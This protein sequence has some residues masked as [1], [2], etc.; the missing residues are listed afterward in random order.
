M[1]AASRQLILILGGA[2]SGKS[3]FGERLAA[4][5]GERI[6]YLATAEASDDEMQARIARHRA[7]RPAQWTTRECPFDPAA[8]L[9]AA[10][11]ETDCFLLDCLTLLVS[12]L[13]LADPASAEETVHCAMDALLT[14]YRETEA[15][16][17]IVSNE[18]GLG[19]VPEYPLGRQYR[20]LLGKV[21]QRLAREA[22]AVYYLVA[23]FPLDI[24]KLAVL[25]RFSTGGF[26]VH[27]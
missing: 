10:A 9:R 12:N 16:L 15:A 7:E 24:K 20:D 2:R 27:D 13:L 26:T 1:A 4:T 17:I 6:T 23:G 25:R 11:P 14:A 21:N 22:D 19:L 18:V 8:A 5:L 3:T